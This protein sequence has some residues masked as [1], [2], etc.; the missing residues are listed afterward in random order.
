MDRV[1]V[2]GAQARE[3]GTLRARDRDHAIA[4]ARERLDHGEAQA[5]AAAGDDYFVH[6]CGRS[7][8]PDSATGRLATARSDAGT[9]CAGSAARQAASNSC[10]TDAKSEAGSRST[11]SAATMAPVIGFL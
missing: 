9:L 3:F 7:S 10:R 8:L 6:A 2:R 4:R 1:L 5:A 11:T